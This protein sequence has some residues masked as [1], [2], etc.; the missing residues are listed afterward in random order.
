[1][2]N[3]KLLTF[4]I[5]LLIAA[6]VSAQPAPVITV[7]SEDSIWLNKLLLTPAVNQVQVVNELGKPSRI[8]EKPGELNLY[9]D[10]LG[11][12]VA[13]KE[14]KFAAIAA[15]FNW[16]GDKH[17]PEKSYTGRLMIGK[18]E[19]TRT[20]TKEELEKNLVIKVVCPIPN[21]CASSNKAANVKALAG[22]ENNAITQLTF[23]LK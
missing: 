22:F 17:F 10:D 13:L 18:M 3:I 7:T 11:I 20:T 12:L 9:Y 8:V 2:K 16:D 1:M 4:S 15:N 21:I 6:V 23:L 19:I 14:G 5:L